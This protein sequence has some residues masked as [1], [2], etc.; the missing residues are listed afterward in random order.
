MS[1]EYVKRLD[2][3]SIFKSKIEKRRHN[4]PFFKEGEVWWCH[5]GENIGIESS[6]KHEEF[7]RPV[8]IFKKYDKYSFLGLPLTTKQKVGSWYVPLTFNGIS[9]TVVLAQ[10][11]TMDHRRLKE[12]ISEL[13]SDDHKKIVNAYRNL[14]IKIDPPQLPAEVVG[15]SQIQSNDSMVENAVKINV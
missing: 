1:E 5:I 2:E 10:G 15:K 12:K 3:W 4:P 13:D 8:F 7:T 11:K 9:Q 14:H 6:G